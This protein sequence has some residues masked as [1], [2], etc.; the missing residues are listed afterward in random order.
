MNVVS[1]DQKLK[2]VDVQRTHQRK[3]VAVLLTHGLVAAAVLAAAPSC[4]A[5]AQP[6]GLDEAQ[7][8]READYR[9]VAARCGTPAFETKFFTQSRNFVAASN[10]N[11]QDSTA[12]Q[13]RA[14]ESLRRNPITLISAQADCKAQSDELKRLLN[15]RSRSHNA[16]RKPGG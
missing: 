8:Q 15:E 3:W 1:Q 16:H 11:R 12:R 5:Q 2:I 14:I 6:F 10:G 9:V 4:W 13:E 7:L